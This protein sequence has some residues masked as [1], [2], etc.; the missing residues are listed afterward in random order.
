MIIAEVAAALGNTGAHELGH[1][2]GGQHHHSYG[3]PGITPANYTNTANI[4]NK[5][6]MAT[7]Q[8][9]IDAIPNDAG[10]EDTTRA[11]SQWEHLQL[12]AAGG[13]L[14]AIHGTTG[15]SLAT[16]VL[17][18]TDS[19]TAGDVGGTIAT[20]KL[21]SLTP[22]PI[23]VLDAANTFSTLSTDLDVDVYKFSILDPGRILADV[24]TTNRYADAFDPILTL[25]STDGTTILASIDD[26]R[27]VGNTYNAGS[28]VSLDSSL[29]NV[30]LPT[31][32]TYFLEVKAFG[33][34][35][36][37]AGGAYNLVFGVAAIPEPMSVLAWGLIIATMSWAHG[38]R[39]KLMSW[40]DVELS[41][42]C[43]SITR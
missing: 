27:Y 22:L 26:T 42:S 31:A 34:A 40:L 4:Q 23:S 35:G 10:R 25:Y 16:T 19:V 14:V 3:D 15:T 24:W 32:G 21:L 33:N 12:E 11:F 30:L 38:S 6:I 5:H 41:K 8:T 13:G 43:Q 9:G 29:V 18:E 36:G 20:A 28:A 17:P 1:G 39:R 2:L 37:P 7:G